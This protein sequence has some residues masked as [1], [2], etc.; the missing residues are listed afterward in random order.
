MNIAKL[1]KSK[2]KSNPK[3]EIGKKVSFCETTKNNHSQTE[4]DTFLEV[5]KNIYAL[6]KEQIVNISTVTTS[7]KSLYIKVNSVPTENHNHYFS[8][9][10]DYKNYQFSLY[11]INFNEIERVCSLEEMQD[12]TGTKN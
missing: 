8:E 11:A 12:I 9:I 1:F 10:T 4:L 7:N 6:E 3:K 5:I 2:P